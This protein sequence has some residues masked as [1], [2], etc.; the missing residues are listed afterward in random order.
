M[1]IFRILEIATAYLL[2]A[3]YPTLSFPHLSQTIP[4]SHP[5]SLP[6]HATPNATPPHQVEFRK[7][8]GQPMVGSQMTFHALRMTA[9]LGS[10]Y[11][12]ENLY[13]KIMAE[14]ANRLSDQ[15]I[16]HFIAQY[17]DVVVS[18]DSDVT[19]TWVVV[20]HLASTMLS[21]VFNGDQ[22]FYI[23]DIVADMPEGMGQGT[24]RYTM[25]TP[26]TREET[27]DEV[28]GAILGRWL[29]NRGL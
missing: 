19:F 23:A 24:I 27:S 10:R 13:L 21:R 2:F 26:A 4:S 11:V 22:N 20:H 15:P 18:F 29:G 25:G 1:E 17:G 16:S 6:T 9:Y 5:S 12:L 3:A 7:R 14:A 28:W 8:A